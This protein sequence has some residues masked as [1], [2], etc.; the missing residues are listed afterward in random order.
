MKVK[1]CIVTFP[2]NSLLC[3]D[4]LHSC[5]AEKEL[6]C[7]YEDTNPSH[8]NILI[9]LE[10]SIMTLKKALAVFPASSMIHSFSDSDLSFSDSDLSKMKYFNDLHLLLESMKCFRNKLCLQKIR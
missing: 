4:I 9:I 3:K 10:I 8:E 1:L 5:V 7:N 6:F 2:G